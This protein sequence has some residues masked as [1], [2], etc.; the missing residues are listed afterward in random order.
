MPPTQPTPSIKGIALQLAV[1]AV[2]QL[3]D[4][5]RL[6]RE[7][8]EL[9]LAPEDLQI[10]EQKVLPGMWYPVASMGRLLE[11]TTQR[12][13]A[14]GGVQALVELGVQ[15]AGQLF[16]SELYRTFVTTAEAWGERAGPTLVR[17]APLLFNFTRWSFEEGSGGMRSFRVRVEEAG[18][19]PEILRFLAQG[20]IRYLAER[21]T[22]VPVRVTSSRPDPETIVYTGLRPATPA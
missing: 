20:F 3:L 4:Q 13:R 22:G 7:E 14:R 6:G 2:N 16:D 15:S 19:F 5:G 1:D 18:E 21:V 17:L 10:L 8:L 11:I 12:V 9:R